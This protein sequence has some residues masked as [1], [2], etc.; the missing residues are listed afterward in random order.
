MT[1]LSL[2][3]LEIEVETLVFG[4]KITFYAV[5]PAAGPAHALPSPSSSSSSSSSSSFCHPW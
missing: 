3:D 2:P 4:F 1:S 5:I